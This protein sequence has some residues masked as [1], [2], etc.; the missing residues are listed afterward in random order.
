M[1]AVETAELVEVLVHRFPP[2]STWPSVDIIPYLFLS[3]KKSSLMSYR[4]ETW[5][6]EPLSCRCSTQ[7]H[8]S[9]HIVAENANHRRN[10]L[11]VFKLDTVASWHCVTLRHTTLLTWFF[12]TLEMDPVPISVGVQLDINRWLLSFCSHR[13]TQIE[14]DP[15]V[16]TPDGK[17]YDVLFIGTG[18]TKKTKKK[19]AAKLQNSLAV[20]Q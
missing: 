5:N 9:R 12:K 19:N 16:K 7:R 13:F 20:D 18:K 17:Y 8:K 11:L 14:V 2:M 3:L 1:F 10:L 4:F 15:Q 6:S